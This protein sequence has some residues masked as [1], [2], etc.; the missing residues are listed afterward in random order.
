MCQKKHLYLGC[1]GV[2]RFCFLDLSGL[3]GDFGAR[4]SDFAECIE[5]TDA[6]STHIFYMGD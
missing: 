3:V 6:H 2:S 5:S 4:K 1:G